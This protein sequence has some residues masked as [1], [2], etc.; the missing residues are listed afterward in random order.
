M[1]HPFIQDLSEFSIEQLQERITGL[2]SK[3]QFAHRMQNGHM[4]NQLYMALESYKKEYNKRMDDMIK[5][6][7]IENRISIQKE[8]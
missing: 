4:L 8:K 1:E 5:K 3:I 6:Q 2:L 7:N